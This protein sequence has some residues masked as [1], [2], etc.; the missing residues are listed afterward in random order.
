MYAR[1]GV[2]EY[3]LVDT[4]EDNVTVLRHDQGEFRVAGT[5]GAGKTLKS[6]TLPGFTLNVD[7]LFRPP[8]A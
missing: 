2:G 4:A 6:P 3:W 8:G 1:Y 5:Y 7:D